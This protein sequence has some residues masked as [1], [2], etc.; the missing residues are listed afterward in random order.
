MKP[1]RRLSA[2][3]S[4]VRPGSVLADVGT[5]HAYLPAFLVQTGVCPRAVAADL[6][7]GPLQNAEKTIAALGLEEKISTRLSDGLDA[8][9]PDDFDDVV[10]AGMG[11]L[12]ITQLLART[13]WLKDKSKRII[14]QPMR[15]PWAVRSFFYENGFEI[16]KETCVSDGAHCYCVMAAEYTGACAAVSP[17]KP[18]VGTLG[19][20]SGEEARLFLRQQRRQLQTRY[21]ALK[22]ADADSGEA[23]ELAVILLDFDRLTKETSN[24]D[25][26]DHS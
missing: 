20:A 19:T 4:L 16:R 11:G 14:A 26:A 12:L 15:H 18:Y 17:A 8:F 21:D 24:D 1:D 5:D 2:V 25:S 6:R 22:A 7:P 23:N 9:G 10:L 13:P 3:A